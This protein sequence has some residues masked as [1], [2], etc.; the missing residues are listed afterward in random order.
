MGHRRQCNL[1]AFAPR[2]RRYNVFSRSVSVMSVDQFAHCRRACRPSIVWC[3]LCLLARLYDLDDVVLQI[4]HD[5]VSKSMPAE[6]EGLEAFM[7]RKEREEAAR[8]QQ[9]AEK[10]IPF[11]RIVG[12]RSLNG[13]LAHLAMEKKAEHDRETEKV[14]E[15]LKFG[16]HDQ[17][18]FA[19]ARRAAS[20]R[21]NH[22]RQ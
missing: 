4:I 8:R 11:Y 6:K 5:F 20:R 9:G 10:P 1:R 21:V 17:L 2:T 14:P 15:W 13:Y 18:A 16:F 12:F 7:E 22:R 19:R 3:E